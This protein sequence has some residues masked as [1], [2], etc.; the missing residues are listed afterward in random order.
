MK[1]PIT[2]SALMIRRDLAEEEYHDKYQNYS[3]NDPRILAEIPQLERFI[4]NTVFEP[5][6]WETM[7]QESS[8]LKK[9]ANGSLGGFVS[10]L[11]YYRASLVEKSLEDEKYEKVY[12]DITQI[13][14][15]LNIQCTWLKMCSYKKDYLWIPAV[16]D[17]ALLNDLRNLD[18]KFVK[19]D[20]VCGTDIADSIRENTHH[21]KYNFSPKNNGAIADFLDFLSSD[22]FLEVSSE[23]RVSPFDFQF[24]I[25]AIKSCDRCLDVKL[26]G[27]LDDRVI[28]LDYFSKCGKL[29]HLE[30]RFL[31]RFLNSNNNYSLVGFI[32]TENSGDEKTQHVGISFD[33]KLN[34]D[35]FF[36]KCKEFHTKDITRI[37]LF[38]T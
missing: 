4:N 23:V 19:G 28:V 29:I 27:K 32:R 9:L 35:R 25:D 8:M 34:F 37:D 22:D 6:F 3:G 38:Y 7:Y 18:W 10:A 33:G 36:K 2:L 30:L 21:F 17:L 16:R 24:F 14:L 12:E 31:Y 13:L 20:E 11:F 1:L 5:S 26:K 15:F